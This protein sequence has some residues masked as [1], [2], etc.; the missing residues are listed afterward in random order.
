MEKYVQL[1]LI[2][3]LVIWSIFTNY[4]INNLSDP[5]SLQSSKSNDIIEILK[6]LIFFFLTMMLVFI[7][8]LLKQIFAFNFVQIAITAIVGP[9]TK[10]MSCYIYVSLD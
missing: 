6:P 5:I 9:L 4:I 7:Y 3:P 2:F 10:Q 1:L 8:F